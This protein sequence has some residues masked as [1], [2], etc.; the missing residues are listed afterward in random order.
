MHGLDYLINHYK[1]WKI[2]SIALPPLGCGNGGL[3]WS[4]VG[5]IIYQ[6][7]SELE[8]PVEIYAPYG[9]KQY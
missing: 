7:L 6:K 8:I 2:E 1:E 9:T 5:P 3:E 4:I